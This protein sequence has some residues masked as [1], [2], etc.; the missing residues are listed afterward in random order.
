MEKQKEKEEKDKQRKEEKEEKEKQRKEEKVCYHLLGILLHKL[1]QM[2]A[3]IKYHAISETYTGQ[4]LITLKKYHSSH[5]CMFLRLI[6]V[7]LTN[8]LY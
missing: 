3:S 8:Y 4:N 1:L 7:I 5:I 2:Q 6:T